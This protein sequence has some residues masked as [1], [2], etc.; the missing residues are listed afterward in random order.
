MGRQPNK[1]HIKNQT[2]LKM[3]IGGKWTKIGKKMD[4]TLKKKATN[5]PRGRK[6][7]KDDDE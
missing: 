1:P 6:N 2:V 5:N 4:V 7:R 3:G